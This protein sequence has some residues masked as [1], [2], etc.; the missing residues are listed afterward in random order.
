[1]VNKNR[2]MKLKRYVFVA[3]I[4]SCGYSFAQTKDAIVD[5]I[6]KEANENSQ[7]EK[8]G[9]E[10]MDIVGPRLVGSPQMKIANDWAVKKYNS[11]GIQAKNE[12]WGE[13]RGWERGISH[14]DMISPRVRSLEGTQL[15]WSPSTDAKGVTAGVIILPDLA[16]SIS[17]QKWLP[18][19]KGKFV[20][21]SMM[22]PTG[23][24][25]YNREE[26]GT[27]ESVEKMKEGR[28][29]KSEAWSARIKKTGY[30]SRTL[31]PVLEKAGAAG[32][33]TSN[34][35]AGFG[36]NKIFGA[37]RKKFLRLIFHWKIM[38][39]FTV[40]QNQAIPLKLKWLHG[41]KNRALC[42]HSIPLL[43]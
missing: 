24:P 33:I 28:A 9:H 10:L 2:H 6:V 34:W 42:Q 17:F 11:W 31:P 41:L 13:W 7:L 14:I 32:I 20:M 3:L 19:A 18:N 1:M 22:Q 25:D 43:K 26:F 39:C 23:R 29:E 15:A 30:T 21:I 40:W 16:D 37:Y 4:L 38:D 36:V 8:L 27:P 5:A 35:S 12:K